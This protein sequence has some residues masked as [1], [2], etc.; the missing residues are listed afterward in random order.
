MILVF[1]DVYTQPISSSHGTRCGLN[2]VSFRI[3]AGEICGLLGPNGSGKST[4]LS[5]ALGLVGVS[6][7]S[8]RL[9]DRDPREHGA[10][11]HGAVGFLPQRNVL[12][13]EMSAATYLAHFATL[14]GLKAFPIEL[15]ARLDQVGLKSAGQRPIV[16]FSRD[17]KQRLELARAMIA[18]PRLLVLDEPAQGLDGD[19]RRDIH[20]ILLALAEEGTAI[21]IA[22][23][24]LDDAD[25]I[26]TRVGIMAGGRLFADGTISTLLAEHAQARRYRLRLAGEISMPAAG[27][28]LPVRI[29]AREADWMIVDILSAHPTEA[30]WRDLMFRGWPI[31]EVVTA[32][33]GLQELYLDLTT[34]SG[35]QPR[36]VA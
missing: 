1:D 15:Q 17:M 28:P 3:D 34:A 29:R 13:H 30:V 25:H 10:L 23:D 24:S 26:Y 19:G 8:V 2:G 33:G 6:S 31:V 22:T 14:F 32:G 18:N 5:V 20:N 16:T 21:L 27:A 4:A 12:R 7:G 36:R 9:F 35:A 11:Q